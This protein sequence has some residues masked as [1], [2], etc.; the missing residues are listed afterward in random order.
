MG[1]ARVKAHPNLSSKGM[2]QY[3]D[4]NVSKPKLKVAQMGMSL[5][6]KGKEKG[7]QKGIGQVVSLFE[8]VA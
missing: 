8:D 6:W 2:G 7:N 1:W 5:N 3:L 4:L